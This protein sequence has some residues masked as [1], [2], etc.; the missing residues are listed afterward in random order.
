[1]DGWRREEGGGRL[2]G[3]RWMADSSRL[4]ADTAA[5]GRQESKRHTGPSCFALP[6]CTGRRDTRYRSRRPHG[7]LRKCP[8]A[9]LLPRAPCLKVAAAVAGDAVSQH[10]VRSVRAFVVLSTRHR[11]AE[12]AAAAAVNKDKTV[13]AEDSTVV[14]LFL[15]SCSQCVPRVYLCGLGR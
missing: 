8:N 9:R 1:M 11:T 4:A 7:W 5:A 6:P 13:P 10:L 3:R 2:N 12:A 15:Y 14:L